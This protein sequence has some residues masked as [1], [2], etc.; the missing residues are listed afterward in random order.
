MERRIWGLKKTK[1]F[2]AK[3]LNGKDLGGFD[4]RVGL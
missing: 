3:F 4:L 1:C 2:F